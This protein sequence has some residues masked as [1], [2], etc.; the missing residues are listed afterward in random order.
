LAGGLALVNSCGLLGGFVGPTV[1]GLI[2]QSTGSATN[3]LIVLAV[4]LIV[5]A[6]CSLRLRH[7]DEDRRARAVYCRDAKKAV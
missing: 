1:M 2:E 3:G 5:A 4:A 6:V 7:G